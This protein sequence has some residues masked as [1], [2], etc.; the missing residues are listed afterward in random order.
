MLTVWLVG[1][2]FALLFCGLLRFYAGASK[3]GKV[4]ITFYCIIWPI[5]LVALF[6]MAA[7]LGWVG[8]FADLTNDD[9]WR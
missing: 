9:G 2:V 6:C 7:G 8:V 5:T 4:E 3:M 1:V